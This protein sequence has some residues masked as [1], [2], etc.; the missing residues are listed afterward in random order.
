MVI[1]V[2]KREGQSFMG[3]SPAVITTC[4]DSRTIISEGF[5]RRVQVVE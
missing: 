4:Y 2:V 1:A 3:F 5:T